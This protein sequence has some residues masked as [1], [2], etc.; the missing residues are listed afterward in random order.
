MQKKQ[1]SIL[2]IKHGAFGDLIQSDGIFKSIKN[3]HH[4]SHF[5][6]L[7][8]SSF[9]ILMEASPYFDEII[10]DNRVSL[11]KFKSYY[12]LV[13]QLY[14]YNF[15]HVYDLQ[16]SQRTSLYKHFFLKNAK[17]I[18]TNRKVHPVSSLQ[19]LIRMLRNDG[20]K[21]KEIFDP[22]LSWMISDVTYLLKKNKISRDYVVL[23]PGSSK[24]HPEK[25]WPFF[26]DI[27][28]EIL[29]MGYDVINIIGPDE[30]NLRGSLHGNIFEKLDWGELAGVIHKS[31]FVIGNDSG[32]SHIASCLK[33]PGVALFGP[34]TSALRSELSRG[35]F[36]TIKANDLNCLSSKK[37]LKII[38]K[39]LTLA[40]K[41]N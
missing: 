36:N 37:L 8:S 20:M 18:T 28:K 2:I 1:Q 34:T 4:N 15:S 3:K 11:L 32:P 17:W 12:S 24:K 5:C 29:G 33:K 21:L 16:N 23:L 30:L 40:K 7:T 6:L 27:A 31:A 9:K 41:H 19:G 38:K 26:K 10:E 39:K 14:S 25:R 35:P 22:D 13:R